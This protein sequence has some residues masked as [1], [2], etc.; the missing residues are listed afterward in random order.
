MSGESKE[1]RENH[2]DSVPAE[3][4]TGRYCLN[5]LAL[6]HVQSDVHCALVTSPSHAYISAE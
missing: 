3:I 2:Q 4:R 5:Q 6:S 1:K